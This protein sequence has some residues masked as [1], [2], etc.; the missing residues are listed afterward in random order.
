MRGQD[1]FSLDRFKRPARC[2]AA[3]Q[4][5]LM[6]GSRPCYEG[7]ACLSRRYEPVRRAMRPFNRS[8]SARW[9]SPSRCAPLPA[10][11]LASGGYRPRRHTQPSSRSCHYCPSRNTRVPGTSYAPPTGKLAEPCI[12]PTSRNVCQ[13]VGSYELSLSQPALHL[14]ELQSRAF[15]LGPV[16][17]TYIG[18]S[19]KKKLGKPVFCG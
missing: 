1:R 15:R 16:V 3:I 12:V 6:I 7:T 10:L 8:D 14:K 18:S 17:L 4:T 11:K 13:R 9:V 19:V 5:G 2:R